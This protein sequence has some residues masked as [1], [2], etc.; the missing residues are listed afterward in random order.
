LNLPQEQSEVEALVKETAAVDKLETE[1]AVEL[2]FGGTSTSQVLTAPACY[3]AFHHTV[4]VL[5]VIL[6]LLRRHNG[7]QLSGGKKQLKHDANDLHTVAEAPPQAVR[8]VGKP[9]LVNSIFPH[10]RV[11]AMQLQ[12]IFAAVVTYPHTRLHIMLAL[13]LV[14]VG[15]Q[16]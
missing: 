16:D 4:G 7:P 3:R 12:L 14:H 10:M 11:H 1:Y 6:S 2:D 13:M 9:T 5:R 15:S 8:A